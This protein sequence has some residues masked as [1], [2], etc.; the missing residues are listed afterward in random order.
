MDKE[1][2]EGMDKITSKVGTLKESK[3]DKIGMFEKA[4]GST[5]DEMVGTDKV[6]EQFDGIKKE[7]ETAMTSAT[8]EFMK[9]ADGMVEKQKEDLE[10]EKPS[11]P[12]YENMPQCL[13]DKV[14]EE[15]KVKFGKEIEEGQQKQQ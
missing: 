10:N 12:I 14:W 2:K 4:S 9:E 7:G 11:L 15:G 5:V 6:N 8:D 13:K 3:K 1:S